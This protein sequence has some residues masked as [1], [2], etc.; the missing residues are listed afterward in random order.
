M[1][2]ISSAFEISHS[3]ILL[4]DDLRDNLILLERILQAAGFRN[5]MSCTG[6]KA[7]LEAI[8]TFKPHLV[9]L[10]LMMPEVDG[11]EFLRQAPQLI[12]EQSYTPILVLTADVS[13]SAKTKALELGAADFLTKPC[14]AI[15]IRIKVSNFLRIHRMQEELQRHSI[16]L[17]DRVRQ[18]T[19]E[20]SLL[21]E[22]LVDARDEAMLA[23]R[24]KSQFLANMNHELRTPMNGVIGLTSLLLTRGFDE[25]TNAHLNSIAA[26][27]GTLLRVLDDILELSE[28][29]RS[30]FSLNL[31]PIDFAMVAEAAIERH[32]S[33]ATAKNLRLQCVSPDLAP[34][35]SIGDSFRVGQVLDYLVSNG[36]KFT[37][38]GKVT[39]SWTWTLGEQKVLATFTVADTGIGI[40]PEQLE[41]VFLSF[42]QAEGSANRR[43]GGAG[44]G[45]T[46][47]RRLVEFMGGNISVDSEVDIGSRFTVQL[48]FDLAEEEIDNISD[49]SVS[50]PHCLPRYLRVLLV[51]DNELNR[52]VALALLQSHH[53]IVDVAANGIEAIEITATHAFDI[54]LMDIQMPICDGLTAA[55]SI[56][57]REDARGINHIPI[58]A[59]TANATARDREACLDAGMIEL[60]P[61]PITVHSIETL[62]Q[63]APH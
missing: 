52:M 57:E 24:V 47:V 40:P 3:P 22:K 7:G 6:G 31:A 27:A 38:H 13:Y 50:K 14:D 58:Y 18:R 30:T 35:T 9:I 43:F 29:E 37:D 39:V 16:D 25:D 21:N 4:V 63:R 62:L 5:L 53:C 36:V 1:R 51:E 2:Q 10:D 17:E 55:R 45:L 60:I 28:F 34:P 11:Y 26:S 23:S 12:P 56:R 61:K 54:V 19:N 44:L 49:T 33:T 59:L 41:Q 42:T 46:L 8:T 48:P 20:L 32:Q 15:E